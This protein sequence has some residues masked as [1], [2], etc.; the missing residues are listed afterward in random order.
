MWFTRY[1][2]SLLLPGAGHITIG[3]TQ[4]GLLWF[5]S[6]LL[7]ANATLLMLFVM[8]VRSGW[9]VAPLVALGLL[10]TFALRVGAVVDVAIVKPRAAR[11]PAW[12]VAVAWVAMVLAASVVS[13]TG[14]RLV[15]AFKVPAGSMIPTI[16]VGDHVFVDKLAMPGRGDV[17]VFRYPKDPTKDFIKRV[18][19]VGGDTIEIRDNVP[20][21]NGQP[22]ERAR[23]EGPC[24]YEDLG[25]LDDERWETRPCEA[26][27]EELGGHRYTV[28]YNVGEAPRS[29]PA[30]TLP[31]NT[32]YVLGDNRD[33][34][35]DSRYW[36]FVPAANVKGVAF[37]VWFSSGKDGIRRERL[38]Q[39]IE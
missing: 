16:E 31:P 17:M 37:V 35:H 9:L 4:R 28:Y 6:C 25:G 21:V 15:E 18:I 14:R 36:G 1:I 29:W 30:V 22:I 8:H 24:S 12:Q 19:A 39:R 32:L 5:S 38:G 34:S 3:K 23:R 2:V 26:F 11:P 27:T 33:N 10:S 13:L 7:L 20:I